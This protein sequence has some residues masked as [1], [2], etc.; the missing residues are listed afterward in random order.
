MPA[1]PFTKVL[2]PPHNLTFRLFSPPLSLSCCS[3]TRVRDCVLFHLE[4]SGVLCWRSITRGRT[5]RQVTKPSPHPRYTSIDL[6]IPVSSSPP[7][8][9]ALSLRGR[10]SHSLFRRVHITVG[11]Y[12]C[13]R[14][15]IC[16]RRVHCRPAISPTRDLNSPG[17]SD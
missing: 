8:E 10:F 11:I 2:L 17:L 15:R 7:G 5:I 12:C 14:L 4:A 6:R 16:V 9:A 3:V 1:Y 13:R